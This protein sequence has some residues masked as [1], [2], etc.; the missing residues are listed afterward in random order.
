VKRALSLIAGACLSFASAH[1]PAFVFA[2]GA[3]AEC[4]VGDRVVLEVDAAPD[5]TLVQRGHVAITEPVGSGYRIEWNVKKLASLPGAVH[6]LLFFHECA[7]A[8]VPTTNELRANCV[9]LQLMRA[10]GRAGF[11]VESR[12]AAY[13][14]AGNDF[15]A[16]TLACANAE[17][18]PAR[19]PG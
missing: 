18:G 19:P 10:A 17:A 13:Y 3:A 6:D 5:S 4:R 1:A 16:K 7:H 2:D 12:L 8:Q 11:A 14:G 9:G 15:W